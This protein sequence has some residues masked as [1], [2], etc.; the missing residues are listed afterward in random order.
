MSRYLQQYKMNEG[1]RQRAVLKIQR[2]ALKST[3][4][5]REEAARLLF[6]GRRFAFPFTAQPEL[7]SDGAIRTLTVLVDFKNH[8]AGNDLPN[9]EAFDANIYGGG[10]RVAKDD[11]PYESVHAYYDRASEGIVDLQGDVFDWHHFSKNREEY[12]P[13]AAPPGPFR[14]RQQQL[15]DNQALFDMAAEVLR[16][17]STHDFSQYDNDNDGDIDLLTIL[18]AGPQGSWASFWW[19]YRW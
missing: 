1:L 5:T 8:R 14:D 19:A 11:S 16:T 3:G 15:L 2:A 9:R 6:R 10:T 4:V 7:K 13:A 18:Y 17:H 12:E